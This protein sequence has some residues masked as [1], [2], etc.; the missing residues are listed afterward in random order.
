MGLEKPFQSSTLGNSHLCWNRYKSTY[1]ITSVYV[2]SLHNEFRRTFDI[3]PLPCQFEI[4]C[5]DGTAFYQT[6]LMTMPFNN[7]IVIE[8]LN[9][10]RNHFDFTGGVIA[11]PCA[12]ISFD[13][14]SFMKHKKHN[15]LSSQQHLQ[16]GCRQIRKKSF[17]H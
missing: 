12:Y 5:A 16:Y 8:G 2:Q 14:R 15:L 17:L 7:Y 3:K 10:K 4:N 9:V 1:S 13:A 11:Q 6:R